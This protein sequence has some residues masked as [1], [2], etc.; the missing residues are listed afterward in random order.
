M[1]F[2]IRLITQYASPA[3]FGLLSLA[4]GAS[5]LAMNVACTP[6]MQAAIHFYPEHVSSGTLEHLRSSLWHTLG[7][8]VS[9]SALVIAVSG[10]VLAALG[11]TTPT[12]VLLLILLLGAECWRSVELN[13]LNTSRQHARYSFWLAADA[14]AR[15]LLGTIAVLLL[16]DSASYILGAHVIAALGLTAIFSPPTPPSPGKQMSDSDLLRSSNLSKK[17]RQQ[18]WR[19]ALP[20]MPLGLIAWTNGLSDRYVVGGLLGVADAGI[21]SA[22]Y[23]LASRP[24]LMIGSALELAI[25]PLYQRAIYEHRYAHSHKLLA[26]WLGCVSACGIIGITAITIWRHEIAG[27]LLGKSYGRAADL[28]PWIAGGNAML[29]SSYVFERV[30]YAFGKTHRVLLIQSCTVL[31]GIITTFIGARY[32]GLEGAARAASVYFLVQLL[33][34]I[35]LAIMTYKQREK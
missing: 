31:T 17:L 1:I 26:L 8:V 6:F 32:W 10:M 3:T 18:I 9:C 15:P 35:F 28:M 13:F 16:G 12:M 5:T 21:Y 4:L 22:A 27:L 7:R 14:W 11:Y 30:C 24:F 34:S 23:G 29:A 33:A 25:R 2:G 20:L 19:Y